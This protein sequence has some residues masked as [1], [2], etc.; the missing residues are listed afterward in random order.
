MPSNGIEAALDRS[1]VEIDDEPIG[2]L[3]LLHYLIRPAALP[4]VTT[5][6]QFA[7]GVSLAGYA[8]EGGPPAPGALVNLVLKWQALTTATDR[9]SYTV[10]V[11]LVTDDGTLAAQHDDPPAEGYASTDH[12]QAGQVVYDDHAIAI[13]ANAPRNLHRFQV[14]LYL[15]STGQRVPLVGAPNGASPD[16]VTLDVG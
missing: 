8:V 9:P 7:T 11:H 6:W 12:W 13:P 15:P 3:R 4:L 14:G 1:L 2:G 10:F 16:T 5:H